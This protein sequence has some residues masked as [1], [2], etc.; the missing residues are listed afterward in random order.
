ME[1]GKNTESRVSFTKTGIRHIRTFSLNVIGFI[2]GL[3]EMRVV[4]IKLQAHLAHL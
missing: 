4:R 1:S 2:F 3:V